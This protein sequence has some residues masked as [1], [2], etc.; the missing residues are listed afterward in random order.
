[1]NRFANTPDLQTPS[2]DNNQQQKSK[3]KKERKSG[4]PFFLNDLGVEQG[5]VAQVVSHHDG[6][7]Q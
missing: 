1:M 2:K 3:E 4:L 6:W 7:I 5:S